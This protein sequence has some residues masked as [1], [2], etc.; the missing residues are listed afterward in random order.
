MN[1]LL[2]NF[3]H[4]QV[5]DFLLVIF[6]DKADEVIVL[7]VESVIHSTMLVC[8]MFTVSTSARILCLCCGQSFSY[9]C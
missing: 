9:T 2:T 3:L 4:L 8:I 6:A 1:N 5:I 7:N